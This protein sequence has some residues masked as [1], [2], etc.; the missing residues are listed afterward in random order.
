[1][2]KFQSTKINHRVFAGTDIVVEPES[3]VTES[4]FR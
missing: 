1:M 3:K 4:Y 2:L